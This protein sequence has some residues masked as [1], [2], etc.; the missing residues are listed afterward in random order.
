MDDNTAPTIHAPSARD[1]T[2][3]VPTVGAPT[4]RTR[5][6]PE[7]WVSLDAALAWVAFGDAVDLSGWNRRFYVGAS[8]WM[9]YAPDAF[10]ADLRAI[11]DAPAQAGS[12]FAREVVEREARRMFAPASPKSLYGLVPGSVQPECLAAA[13]RTILADTGDEAQGR[14]MREALW[15]ASNDLRRAIASGAIKAFG[16]P[17]HDHADVGLY[18]ANRARERI[19]PDVCAAPVTLGQGGIWPFALGDITG[20]LGDE[21]ETLWHEILI[22]APELLHAFPAPDDGEPTASYHL[23]PANKPARGGRP[24]HVARKAC[25]KEMMRRANGLNGLGD[26]SECTRAIIE[27]AATKF[28]DA[29]PSDTTVRDLV[30]EFWPGD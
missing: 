1:A 3:A 16:H 10:L 12:S 17:G 20:T 11:A 27:W 6:V 29:A 7:G 5:V 9:E 21:M 18:P 4:L 26:Q 24:P 2:A 23:T 13:A 22:D 30:R 19:P 8:L 15:R 25:I 28:G 14:K